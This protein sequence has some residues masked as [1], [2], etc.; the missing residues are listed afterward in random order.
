VKIKGAKR[1]YSLQ[2]AFPRRKRKQKRK[3]KKRKEIEHL[4]QVATRTTQKVIY[5]AKTNL[6]LV[7]GT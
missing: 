6:E 7:A 4:G 3:T 1:M 2:R 5:V